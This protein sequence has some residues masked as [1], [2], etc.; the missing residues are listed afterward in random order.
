MLRA[1]SLHALLFLV[2]LAVPRVARAQLALRSSTLVN[3]SFAVVGNTVVDCPSTSACD[4]NTTI[5]LPVDK[6]PLVLGD[7]DADGD[8]D[9]TASSAATLVLAGGA[10]VR[11][12]TLYL[13]AYAADVTTRPFGPGWITGPLDPVDFGA[14]FVP[15]GWARCC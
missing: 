3:G 12:A 15:P 11:S 8:D 6:D 5:L 4:N 1:L 2:V 14:L 10:V 9:T 13:G 7:R